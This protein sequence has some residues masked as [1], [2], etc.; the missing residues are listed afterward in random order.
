MEEPINRLI[1]QDPNQKSNHLQVHVLDTSADQSVDLSER[2][3]SRL[4]YG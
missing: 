1:Y 3:G 4:S 2:T